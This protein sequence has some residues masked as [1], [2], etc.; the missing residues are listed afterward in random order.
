MTSIVFD[1]N[2]TL[3]DLKA[4]NP[5]FERI[6]GT[7]AAKD[8]WF[9]QVL[10]TALVS[11]IIGTSA[12]LDFGQVGRIALEFMAL[13]HQVQ[14]TAEDKESIAQTMLNLPPHPEVLPAMKRLY[15]AGK[16]LVALTNSAQQAAETQL[17]NA[18]IAVYLDKVMS[19]QSVG[20]F[21]PAV[22]VYRMA[23]R[24]LD[25]APDD[26]WLVAAH[27]WDIAG[28]LNAGWHGAFIA[29]S[30]KVFHPAGPQPEIIAHN[31]MGVVDQL[32]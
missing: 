32:L 20:K 11:T 12:Q 22:E 27:D 30:G 23:E 10:Q 3:L 18:G 31:L 1:V 2:E 26:L 29:R 13:R 19:V 14:L 8:A 7:A 24:T 28:A 5:H 25:E 6:F 16:R 17:S 4:L 15:N 9:N 21:K